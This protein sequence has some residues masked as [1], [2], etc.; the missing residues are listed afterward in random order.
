MS[1][2]VIASVDEMKGDICL[3]AEEVVGKAMDVVL[4]LESERLIKPGMYR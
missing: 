3:I 4:M 1:E 2:I